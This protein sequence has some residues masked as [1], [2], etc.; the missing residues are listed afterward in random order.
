MLTS[1]NPE[2]SFSSGSSTTMKIRGAAIA[3]K[4]LIALVKE[5]G[6]TTPWEDKMRQEIAALRVI[7]KKK[8]YFNKKA[9]GQ[10]I[11]RGADG[12]EVV[13]RKC[14]LVQHSAFGQESWATFFS[15]ATRFPLLR[16][17]S[18]L[19]CGYSGI[20]D[21]DSGLEWKYWMFSRIFCCWLSRTWP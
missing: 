1:I 6:N 9:N 8:Q 7:S 15:R 16:F 20:T 10:I 19:Q 11:C 17:R 12:V 18:V 5:S 4:W 3:L 2:V 14:V 13:S 21:K